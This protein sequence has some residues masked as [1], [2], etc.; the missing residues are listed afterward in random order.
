[1][2]PRYC[3]TE[4]KDGRAFRSSNKRTEPFKSLPGTLTWKLQGENLTGTW[5]A[6]LASGLSSPPPDCVSSSDPASDAGCSLISCHRPEL[7][8][9]RRRSMLRTVKFGLGSSM[10]YHRF[11]DTINVHNQQLSLFVRHPCNILFTQC[12]LTNWRKIE[13]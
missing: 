12:V 5:P 9:L 2:Q 4:D 6:L 13:S 1:M 11:T 8:H 3:N 7:K 10:S